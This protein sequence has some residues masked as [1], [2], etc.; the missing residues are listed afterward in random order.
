MARDRVG[1]RGGASRGAGVRLVRVCVRDRDRALLPQRARA[2]HLRGDDADPQ[3][4]A[5]RARAGVSRAERPRRRGVPA[6]LVGAGARRS[7]PVMRRVTVAGISGSGKSTFARGLAERLGV[8]Y[9]ELDELHHGPNWT[10]ATADELRARVETAI[11]AAPE[12][13]V[14]DGNYRNKLGDFVL[15]QADTFVW[16]ELPLRVSM[17]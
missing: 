2:D 17:W 8:P 10:E 4:D 13:W 12:G 16:L 11:A 14:I 7:S 6:V 9:L 5:G 15:A 1:V 3:A